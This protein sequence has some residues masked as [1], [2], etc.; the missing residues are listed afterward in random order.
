M[1]EIWVIGTDP[2][3]PRCALMTRRVKAAAEKSRLQVKLRHLSYSDPVAQRFAESH[4]QETGTAKDVARLSGIE[5]D[6]D[7]INAVIARQWIDA[8][9]RMDC[10]PEDVPVED[11]WS[12]ELDIALKPFQDEAKRIGYMM[13][14]VLVVNGELKHQGSVLSVDQIR[15]IIEALGSAQSY[16]DRK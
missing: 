7:T 9:K 3:C 8:A 5:M 15:V 1:N 6:L 4:G 10:S 12:P 13:T 2:P 16:Q 11:R 14:P